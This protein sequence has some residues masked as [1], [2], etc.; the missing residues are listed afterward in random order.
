MLR[1][2]SVLK[3]LFFLQKHSSP[4][5]ILVNGLSSLSPLCPGS[6]NP[7][8]PCSVL[9]AHYTRPL[10]TSTEFRRGHEEIRGRRHWGN[11]GE[12]ARRKKNTRQSKERHYYDRKGRERERGGGLGFSVFSCSRSI[13]V[14]CRGHLTNA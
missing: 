13:T 6:C 5:F 1:N 9:S 3:Y 2:G 4:K 14:M 7:R 10:V 8:F 11:D 12:R